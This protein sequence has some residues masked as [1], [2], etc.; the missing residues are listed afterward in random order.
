MTLAERIAPSDLA[1]ALDWW[2]EAGVDSV[3][4]DEATNW[5]T[6]PVP[7]NSAAEAAPALRSARFAPTPAPAPA[8]I[9]LFGGAPPADLAAFREWWL[10]E[11]ALDAIGPRGRV[12]PRGMAR[13]Q[14]MV[15]VM[16][17]EAGDTT[18]LLSQ[19]QGR[20]LGRILAAMAVPDGEIYVASVLPRHTPMAD[21]VALTRQGYREVL[22]HHVQLVAPRRIV[23]FGVNILPLLG[24]DA[25]QDPA[26]VEFFKLEGSSV[27]LL[28]SEGLDS[29]MA[30]PRLKARFWRRWL[31]W[32]GRQ[33]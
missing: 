10:A 8:Q 20:L 21:G 13:T 23:A 26:A 18:A 4:T 32:T 7:A 25:A 22:S 27:P 3:F 19:A 31:D 12:P 28:V 1:A 2:R 9:D 29:M 24:H 14:L 6:G 5:L 30:M 11:P 33:A 16:D 15:L 17:P